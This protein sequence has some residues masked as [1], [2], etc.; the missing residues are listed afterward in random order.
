[1]PHH[2]SSVVMIKRNT[3]CL[4]YRIQFKT[5]QAGRRNLA[6]PTVST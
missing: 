3:Y 4:G 1:M 5:V 6:I 2:H